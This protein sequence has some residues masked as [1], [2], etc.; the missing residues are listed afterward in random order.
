MIFAARGKKIECGETESADEDKENAAEN[1][2]EEAKKKTKR[3]LSQKT[4]II[5]GIIFILGL[6]NVIIFIPGNP[7]ENPQQT[8]LTKESTHRQDMG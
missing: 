3:Q 1:N 4:K 5:T 6:V 8:L 2:S 7:R